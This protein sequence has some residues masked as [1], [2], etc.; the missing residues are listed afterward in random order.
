MTKDMKK[1]DSFDDVL[2]AYA[3]IVGHSFYSC[4]ENVYAEECRRLEKH[5]VTKFYL[6]DEGENRPKIFAIYNIDGYP[7]QRTE[8]ILA[9]I[10]IGSMLADG[11]MQL[12]IVSD[13]VGVMVPTRIVCK[14]GDMKARAFMAG[15]CEKSELQLVMTDQY[16]WMQGDMLCVR[17]MW[18]HEREILKEKCGIKSKEAA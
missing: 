7:L 13:E 18:K 5:N 4:F 11:L 10:T 1:F 3:E 9:E 8:P 15:L 2:A 16:E 17:K 14:K 12:V 6:S